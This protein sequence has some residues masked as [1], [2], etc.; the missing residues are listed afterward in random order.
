VTRETSAGPRGARHPGHDLSLQ[1]KGHSSDRREQDALVARRNRAAQTKGLIEGQLEVL[2]RAGKKCPPMEA[3]A[4]RLFDELENHN[5]AIVAAP[6]TSWRDVVE[7]LSIA[8]RWAELERED[9]AEAIS[10]TARRKLRAYSPST[11]RR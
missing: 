2:D 8:E 6:I 9:V 1:W 10:S 3:E 7:K 4:D 5:E 11:L